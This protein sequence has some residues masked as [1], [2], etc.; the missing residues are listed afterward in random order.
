MIRF[1]KGNLAM[2]GENEAVIDSQGIG[3]AIS[4]P[5]SVL[6]QLPAIGQEVL[7]YTYL[8]VREDAMQLFGFLS[9]DDLKLFRLLITVNGVGPKA[10]LGMMGAM[11]TYEI[12]CAV[13]SGDTKAISRAPGIG[14]KTA[15]KII[16]ELKDKFDAVELLADDFALEQQKADSD[17]QQTG[18]VQDAV[19][20]L[21]VLGYP[22][23]DALRAVRMV[24]LSE[25][26][27]VEELLKQSLRNL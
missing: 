9:V 15:G 22:R 21:T 25:E 11:T 4:V 7:L 26:M 23:T 3:Y 20:A 8:N 13:L 12:R 19:E 16:L 10:A 14:P 1:V 17:A 6:E 2:V 27:T 24:G 5:Y 18:V